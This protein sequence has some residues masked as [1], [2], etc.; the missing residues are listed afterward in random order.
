MTIIRN[1]AKYN[2]VCSCGII[3]SGT[4]ERVQNSRGKQSI[5]VRATEV[6]L[7]I[8]SWIIALKLETVKT[9]SKP[10]TIINKR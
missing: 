2:N 6:L 5:C 9:L 3:L 10:E 8:V 1:Y 4:Q 7:Y